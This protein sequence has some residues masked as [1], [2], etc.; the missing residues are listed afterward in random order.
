M[1]NLNQPLHHFATTLK[2]LN[3]IPSFHDCHIGANHFQCG[4]RFGRFFMK[5][6]H[7]LFYAFNS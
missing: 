3:I 2:L 4:C 6:K 1:D 7:N 5:H